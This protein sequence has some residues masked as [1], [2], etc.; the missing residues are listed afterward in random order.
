MDDRLLRVESTLNDLERSLA[1]LDRRVSAVEQRIADAQPS[2]SPSFG[3]REE[4][5]AL[6]AQRHTLGPANAA[7]IPGVVPVLSHVGRT[8]VAL[9]GA[10]LLRALTDSA[11]LPV[12]EGIALGLVYAIVWLTAADRAAASARR[13]SASF[14]VAAAS[15]VAFP[16]IWEAATKFAVL[17]PS[18]AA[19]VLTGFTALGLAVAARQGL[20]GGAWIVT[21]AA[22]A[23]IV[24]LVAETGVL[25]PFATVSVLLGIATLWI[26]YTTDWTLLRWPAA[27]AADLLVLALPMRLASGEAADTAGVVLGLQLL[28]LTAYLVSVA[29]RTLFRDRDVNAFEV[30]QSTAALVIGFGGA[31]YVSR[32]AGSG[33]TWLAVANLLIGAGCYAVAFAFVARHPG[34]RRNLYFYTSLALVLVLVSAVL[35]LNPSTLALLSIVLAAATTRLGYLP[36]KVPLVHHAAVYA[37]VA[38][39]ASGLLSAATGAIIR[40]VSEW[41]PF[42]AAAVA[43]LTVLGAIWIRPPGR[44]GPAVAVRWPRLVMAAAFFWCL[45]GGVVAV[46]TPAIAALLAGASDG[47]LATTRTAA[48]GALAVLLAWIGRH[49]RFPEAGWLLYPA[50]ATGGVKL[51]IE[52]LPRSK[53]SALFIALA[54]YGI[55]L[56]AA[57]RLHHPQTR[58]R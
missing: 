16:L 31:L 39:V 25:A 4:A 33:T 6:D 50:L 44:A 10:F 58:A 53:P 52:D 57:P 35:L 11:I 21:A 7:G 27:I 15:L 24:V 51:L 9:G 26:G 17:G 2:I 47:V 23:I 37:M 55:A 49:D 12:R 5:A 34:G 43:V 45:C 36:A 41:P 38:V 28:L 46:A 3:G 32:T 48:L 18:G 54:V 19:A 40:P 29:V 8:F 1:A 20:H 22:L 14:H 56:I 30:L 13:L 42:S